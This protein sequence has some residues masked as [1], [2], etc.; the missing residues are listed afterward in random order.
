MSSDAVQNLKSLI[1]DIDNHLEE[2]NTSLN[3]RFPPEVTDLDSCI[4]VIL[5]DVSNFPTISNKSKK[6]FQEVREEVVVLKNLASSDMSIEIY[7]KENV[8]LILRND[9]RDQY[10][11]TVSGF[12]RQLANLIGYGIS[13]M[14]PNVLHQM[15]QKVT[16]LHRNE[17]MIQTRNDLT[18]NMKNITRK[19]FNEIM[20][21][22]IPYQYLCAIWK[23]LVLY[24]YCIF[25]VNSSHGDLHIRGAISEIEYDRSSDIRLLQCFVEPTKDSVLAIFLY[26]RLFW[27]PMQIC[28]NSLSCSQR[29]NH[30][31]EGRYKIFPATFRKSY[32]HKTNFF[33][34]L[35][36]SSG[37][38][39]CMQFRFQPV[40]EEES[41]FHIFLV[42][43]RNLYL[44]MG[45]KFCVRFIKGNPQ[46]DERAIWKI[47]KISG[48]GVNCYMLA[49]KESK[50]ALLTFGLFGRVY[51]SRSQPSDKHLWIFDVVQEDSNSV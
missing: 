41:Q 42:D 23:I 32:V 10:K 20:K 4:D 24:L 36:C 7:L 5:T 16:L 51:G 12:V 43:S 15:L 26:N 21:V 30:L 18:E 14:N 31:R 44:R 13:H 22:L 34:F 11:N 19:N 47:V 8:S 1:V 49:T 27:Q 3:L 2:N 50:D 25:D 28:V 38:H 46:G 39:K 40:N 9:Q 48:K 29:N 33:S 35:R 45:C 37:N 17:F 6:I